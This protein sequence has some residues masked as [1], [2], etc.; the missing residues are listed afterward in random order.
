[1]KRINQTGVIILDMFDLICLSISFGAT[2]VCFYNI[3]KEHKE[4]RNGN[5]SLVTDLREKSPIVTYSEKGKPLKLPS[6]RGGDMENLQGY[7]PNDQLSK[8]FKIVFSTVIKSRKFFEIW[9]SIMYARK[10]KRHLKLLQFVF[11]IGNAVLTKSVG[12]RVAIGGSYSYTE[13][14]IISFA[15]TISGVVLA[16]ISKYPYIAATIPLGLVYGRGIEAVDLPNPAEKCRIIC[17]AAEQIHNKQMLIEM[18]QLTPLV[19]N[20]S[21]ALDLP[22]EPVYVACVEE[23]LS[24]VERFKLKEVIRSEKAKKRIQNFS[25]FIKKFPEC[26]VDPNVVYPEI[27]KKV[28]KN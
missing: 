6:I 18:K 25:Q 20:T 26:D 24:I 5:D 12:L 15:S 4:R 10:A 17:K 27:V 16:L 11:M 9:Q 3:Y 21:A 7:P 14:I 23:K 8:N 13:I 19:K 1:M 2:L 22:V 28:I